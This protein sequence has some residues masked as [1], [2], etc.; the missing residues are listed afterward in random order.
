VIDKNDDNDK[1][2]NDEWPVRC[3]IIL[4]FFVRPCGPLLLSPINQPDLPFGH[5][6]SDTSSTGMISFSFEAVVDSC[7]SI[8]D[9][10]KPLARATAR[11]MAF[12]A[13][14]DTSLCGKS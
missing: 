10:R 4:W 13:V 9:N 6:V 11:I 7:R 3:D 5:N 1:T 14:V 12:T 8:I 2:K